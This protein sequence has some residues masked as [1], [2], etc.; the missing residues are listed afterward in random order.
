MDGDDDEDDAGGNDAD[1]QG[2][3]SQNKGV[4]RNVVKQVCYLMAII[5]DAMEKQQKANQEMDAVMASTVPKKPRGV[6]DSC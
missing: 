3:D 1:D 4:L 5:I 2:D 6:C